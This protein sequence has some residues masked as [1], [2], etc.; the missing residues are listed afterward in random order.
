ME[1]PFLSAEELL[2]HAGWLRGLARR[3]VGEAHADDVLQE[4]WKTALERPPRSRAALPAWLAQ[5]ARNA[6]RQ[7]RRSET[8]RH[9]RETKSAKADIDMSAAAVVERADLHRLMVDEVMALDEPY[10]QVLLLR[11][12]EER[13]PAEIAALIG[14][15]AL[16]HLEAPVQRVAGFDVIFPLAKNE[17]LYLP[18]RDRIAKSVRK[19]MEF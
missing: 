19:T 15:H 5:V 7:I 8:A 16:L 3:L 11:W 17:K 14:E 4:T 6:A 12:F 13:E 18:T 9:K 2:Q 1:P 10:R